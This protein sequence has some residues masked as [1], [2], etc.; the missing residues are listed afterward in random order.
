MLPLHGAHAAFFMVPKEERISLNG[1]L[2]S[3]D[4]HDFFKLVLIKF[5]ALHR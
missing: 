3:Q 2:S 4:F 5:F 1:T